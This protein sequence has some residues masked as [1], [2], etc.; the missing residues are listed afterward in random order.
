MNKQLILLLLAALVACTTKKETYPVGQINTEKGEILFW[1]YN[2]TP[3]HKA[4]FIKF[5]F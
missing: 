4:S 1:L 5:T 2:E 3:N